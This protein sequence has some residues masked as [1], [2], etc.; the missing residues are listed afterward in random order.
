MENS[1]DQG[2]EDESV[3]MGLVRPTGK[4]RK[5]SGRFRGLEYYEEGRDN[6]LEKFPC[7]HPHHCASFS[8][9]LAE[10]RL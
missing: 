10:G 5:V 4:P 2:Q 6:L 8:P 3:G 1:L 9:A 7:L